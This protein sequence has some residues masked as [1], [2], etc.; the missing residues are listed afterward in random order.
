M[1]KTLRSLVF[2][3]TLVL[4]AT[5]ACASDSAEALAWL[6]ETEG[7]LHAFALRDV[8]AV[9]HAMGSEMPARALLDAFWESE[10]GVQER[11]ANR[12]AFKEIFGY[13]AAALLA[14]GDLDEAVS[15]HQQARLEAAEKEQAEATRKTEAR[16]R[17]LEKAEEE[18]RKRAAAEAEAEARNAQDYDRAAQMLAGGL[19]NEAGK[20]FL[21]LGAYSDAAQRAE[22]CSL[23]LNGEEYLKAQALLESGDFLGAFGAFMGIHAFQ[24]AE[25]KAQ[26][27]IQAFIRLKTGEAEE[28]LRRSPPRYA[29]FNALVKAIQQAEGLSQASF[30]VY[31]D[32]LFSIG[33]VAI[34]GKDHELA[35]DVFGFL[36]GE[37]VEGA[38]EMYLRAGEVAR[39]IIAVTGGCCP[40]YI[41]RDGGVAGPAVEVY[42]G[43]A[44]WEEVVD[45]DSNLFY[46]VGLR[47]DGTV[48]IAPNPFF[49]EGG[50]KLS[51]SLPDLSAWKDVRS[52]SAGANYVVAVTKNGSI[53]SA[54]DDSYGQR[55]FPTAGQVS[56]ASAGQFFTLLL[57]DG[58][59]SAYGSNLFGQHHLNEKTKCASVSAGAFHSLTL[60]PR[61]SVRAAGLNVDGQCE[62][63][64]WKDIT[65]IAAG[66]Y[67]SVGLRSDGTVVAVGLNDNRQCEVSGW[68][69]IIA[70]AAGNTFTVALS[71]DGTVLTTAGEDRCQPHASSRWMSASALEWP[72]MAVDSRQP[73][74]GFESAKK[75]DIVKFGRYEQDNDP[76][77][78]PEQIEWR[79]LETSED[80]LLLISEKNLD[81]KQYNEEWASISWE[82]CTLR[83]WLN[84]EFLNAAFT[85][86]E[87]QAILTTDV[88][89]ENNPK[90]GTEGGNDTQDRVFILSI[91]EAERYFR[92]NEERQ[93]ENTA[94]AKAQGTFDG[95]GFG[96]WW[97]RSPGSR[98]LSAASVTAIGSVDAN[99]YGVIYEREAVR[100]AFWVNLEPSNLLVQREE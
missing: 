5:P 7:G 97:L 89:N 94:Y 61:G 41:R 6:R 10:P 58:L 48:S 17:A 15:T 93:A 90:Y 46:A 38:E 14:S 55:A 75:G 53:L 2:F 11:Y 59:A 36:R 22:E 98:T 60:L 84:G 78:G 45:A 50:S 40:F 4:A 35:L 32:A 25:E 87:Q 24:D 95:K 57:R 21:L 16:S 27:A 51:V 88:K 47:R 9:L 43:S 34:D 26:Q 52:I 54:G 1:L 39:E 18:T 28:G 92:S 20:L 64:S 42:P 67:H 37:G 99:G 86:E 13:A 91:G 77:N 100:P 30:S 33:R 29:A 69:D 62:V 3:L 81:C 31:H 71:K 85:P 70:V 74:Y 82:T 44:S 23:I 8:D 76:D 56:M 72:S 73:D 80:R 66:A 63:K 65:A 68:T 19:F 83:G 79:V 12:N 49:Y 96:W